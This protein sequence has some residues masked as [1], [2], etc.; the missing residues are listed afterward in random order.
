MHVPVRGRGQGDIPSCASRG[1]SE[2]DSGECFVEVCSSE[3]ELK[4][5]V[6]LPLTPPASPLPSFPHRS[7][8]E[9]S[10][11]ENCDHSK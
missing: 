10:Y 3:L 4:Q 7:S 5:Y 2:S 11:L 6:V 1:L 8:V 9:V